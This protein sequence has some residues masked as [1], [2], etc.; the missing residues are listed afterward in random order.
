MSKGLADAIEEDLSAGEETRRR[1]EML[2]REAAESPVDWE[3][4]VAE[5]D[6]EAN[7]KPVG[8]YRSGSEKH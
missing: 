2:M 7:R 5:Y 1:H 6:R 4:A 8:V 3:I